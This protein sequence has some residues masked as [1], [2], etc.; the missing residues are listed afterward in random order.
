M[1]L[2]TSDVRRKSLCVA[3]KRTSDSGIFEGVSWGVQDQYNFRC[4][5]HWFRREVIGCDKSHG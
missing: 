3:T 5:E 1:L 4:A 2:S